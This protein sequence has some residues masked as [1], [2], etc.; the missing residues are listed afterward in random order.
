MVQ[1]ALDHDTATQDQEKAG[2]NYKCH[3]A[4]LSFGVLHKSDPSGAF[5]EPLI[6]KDVHPCVSL[7]FSSQRGF[8][9]SSGE[10]GKYRNGKHGQTSVSMNEAVRRRPL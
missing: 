8:L 7:Q 5:D 2:S 1:Q 6:K 3:D 10:T 4:F 9:F